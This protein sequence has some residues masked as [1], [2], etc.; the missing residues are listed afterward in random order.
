[1]KKTL[2]DLCPFTEKCIVNK[3][4]T[5]ICENYAACRLYQALIKREYLKNRN[6][7]NNRQ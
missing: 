1:M 6:I 2:E 7:R 3:A 4:K 5:Q